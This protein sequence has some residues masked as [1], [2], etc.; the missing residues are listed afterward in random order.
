MQIMCQR[1]RL[2]AGLLLTLHEKSHEK[3][4]ALESYIDTLKIDHLVEA[5]KQLYG[6]NKE[7]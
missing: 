6:F 4:A 5:V 1:M 3:E 2:L 7:S